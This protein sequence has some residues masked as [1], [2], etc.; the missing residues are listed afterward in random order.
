VEVDVK[1]RTTLKIFSVMSIFLFV[2]G[3]DARPKSVGKTQ[4]QGDAKA[5]LNDFQ[6]LSGHWEG[7][8][9][10]TPL[11][12][13]CSNPD[14]GLMM[15]MFRSMNA[16]KILALELITLQDTPDGVEERVRFF[17][18]DLS[19]PESA[20]AMV[21]RVTH[22]API[23]SV[24]ENSNP[25]GASKVTLTHNAPDEMTARIELLDDSGKPAVIEAHWKRVH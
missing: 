21:L 9:G 8:V 19:E 2:F 18:P 20:K 10:T 11:E 1:R 17:S 14:R 24:F 3:R 5:S 7:L 25:G 12:E 22:F 4:P 16:Q 13:F 15:C 23:E 6:W